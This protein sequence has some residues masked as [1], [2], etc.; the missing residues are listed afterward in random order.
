[1]REAG[2]HTGILGKWHSAGPLPHE[3]GC[4]DETLCSNSAFVNYHHPRFLRNGTPESR[5][6]YSTDWLAEEAESFIERNQAKPFALTVTFNAPHILSLAK[7]V[8]TTVAEWKKGLET[9]K[10]VDVNK[11]PTARPG[12]AQ[13]Y[14]GQFPGDTARADTVATIMALDQAVGRI[15]DKLKETGLDKKTVVF[16][17]SD[18]GGHFENRSENLPLRDYK[19]SLY[20]GG[21]RVP[22]LA[23]Y[24]GVF[25]AGLSF[26][27]PVMTLDIFATCAALAG[28]RAPANLD[29][30]NLTPYLTGKKSTPPHEALYFGLDYFGHYLG[31]IRQGEWKLKLVDGK[32]PELFNVAKDFEEKHDLVS[33]E[34]ERVQELTKKW[35]DWN[36]QMPAAKAPDNAKPGKR[37]GQDAAIHAEPSEAVE[38]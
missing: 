21:I 34:P 19:W 26:D 20:E 18:N 30:V 15:L 2:Y 33:S 29:G 1:M 23:A 7:G 16:F 25:A 9:G 8:G 37:K 11:V 10:V 24:P 38:Q 28:A 3:R 5:D 6:E 27:H 17:F 13:Q 35:N 14:A 36:A 32:K 12:E 22:F 31:A 4:F